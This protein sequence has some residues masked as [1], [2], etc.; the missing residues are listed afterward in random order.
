MKPQE[1]IYV[2]D[3]TQ[4]AI[5]TTV[6]FYK[7][8][9]PALSEM[10]NT[11]DIHDSYDDYWEVRQIVLAYAKQEYEFWSD[12]SKKELRQI[13][14]TM[15]TEKIIEYYYEEVTNS[16]WS[17]STRHDIRE[18]FY[19][20]F[21]GDP[22]NFVKFTNPTDY[23]DPVIQVGSGVYLDKNNSETHRNGQPFLMRDD[24]LHDGAY[25]VSKVLGDGTFMLHNDTKYGYHKNWLTLYE[26]PDPRIYGP[27]AMPAQPWQLNYAGSETFKMQMTFNPEEIQMATTPIV[28]KPTLINGE[29]I[30]HF[31]DDQIFA[32]IASTEK[33]IAR[34]QAQETKPKK[35]EAR[36][37]MHKADI[38]AL[39]EIVDGRE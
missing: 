37:D 39:V 9:I 23:A 26:E 12:R 17:E 2:I 33:E 24:M 11:H 4:L 6:A 16:D 21:R 38:K 29:P 36:I 20:G 7:K 8:I 14:L 3:N 13:A 30:D 19:C 31:S 1:L 32:L 15:L 10:L 35:L 27:D 28:T 22:A 18:E 5:S 34:L 25:T